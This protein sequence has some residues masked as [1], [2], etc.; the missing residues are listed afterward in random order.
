MPS[1]AATSRVSRRTRLFVA[2]R[3]PASRTGTSNVLRS[4]TAQTATSAAPAVPMGGSSG[5]TPTALPVL[6]ACHWLSIWARC[7]LPE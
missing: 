5:A 4:S 6:G 2:A 3:I 7:S 1:T